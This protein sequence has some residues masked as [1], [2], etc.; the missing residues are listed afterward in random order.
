MIKRN[1]SGPWLILKNN[2]LQNVLMRLEGKVKLSTYLIE[3]FA[4]LNCGE[5]EVASII[6]NI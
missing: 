2:N 6:L 5:N 1:D 3:S 4:L